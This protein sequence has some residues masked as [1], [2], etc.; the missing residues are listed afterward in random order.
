MDLRSEILDQTLTIRL[1]EPRLDAAIALQFKD[2]VR[3]MV[4]QAPERVVLDIASVHFLDSS[5]LGAIVAVMKAV[6]ANRQFLLAGVTPNVARVLRLTRMDTVLSILP[7]PIDDDGPPANDRHGS[8]HAQQ[9]G[10]T[11]PARRAGG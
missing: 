11:A 9:A 1:D 8:W 2:S 7:P 4:A 3:Q 5:G 6:G 10:P